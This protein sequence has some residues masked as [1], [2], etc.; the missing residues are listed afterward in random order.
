MLRRLFLLATLCLIAAVAQTPDPAPPPAQKQERNTQT[1]TLP[2]DKLEKA[3]E[4]AKSRHRAYFLGVAYGVVVLWALLCW[5]VG[6]RYRDFAHRI[7]RRRIVQAYTFGPLFLLTADVLQLPLS[8]YDHHLSL[9]YQQ[10]IQGWGSWFWDWTKGEL[11]SFV[12]AGVLLWILYAI[13]RRSPRRWWFHFWLAAVPIIVFLMFLTPVV[14][15]PLFFKFEP[16]ADKQPRLVAEIERV[17]ARGGLDIPT[18]RMYEMKA[19]EKL[20]SLNAYVTGLGASKRVVVWDTTI[21]KMNPGQIL[22]VFGHEMGHY[23][24]HHIWA[25]IAMTAVVVLVFLF[26]GYH[27]MN[28]ALARWGVSFSIHGVDD[29]AS[30][31]VLLLVL[32]IFGFLAE[33]VL[34]GFSRTLEHNADIYGLEVIHGIVSNSPESA[35]GAFQILGEV[36]LDDPNPSEFIKF[37]LYNH[38]S[39]SDR[40]RFASQYDPWSNNQFPKYVH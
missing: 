17:V 11:I 19:S 33:P 25:G 22:F 36:G 16:L 8:A 29:W 28:W 1:Y 39:I 35:A 30:L 40:V 6:P 21:Q 31:P 10:S 18:S 15:E 20:N 23:V 3:V 27:A 7:S 12:L 24:L 5:R 34:N 26:L 32:T 13:M 38:P 4:F 14:I 9:K 37:W 2:A